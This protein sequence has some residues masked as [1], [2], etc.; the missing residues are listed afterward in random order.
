MPRSPSRRRPIPNGV[1]PHVRLLV[2]V[3][4]DQHDSL[5][6]E[7]RSF[8]RLGWAVAF[9]VFAL[10]V[11]LVLALIETRGVDSSKVVDGTVRVVES[12]RGSDT[13]APAPPPAGD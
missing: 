10:Q 9:G 8:R 12:V 2:E 1:D 13:E 4:D 3:I 7:I 6:G 5:L 11:L